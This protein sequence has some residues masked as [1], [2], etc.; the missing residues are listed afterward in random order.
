MQAVTGLWQV[1]MPPWEYFTELSWAGPTMKK[2]QLD[3]RREKVLTG[4]RTLFELSIV[5]RE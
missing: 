3:N 4:K 5:H 2:T 1:N